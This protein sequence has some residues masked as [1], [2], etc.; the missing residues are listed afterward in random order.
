M[1]AKAVI[2]SLVVVFILAQNSG[3][4]DSVDIAQGDTAD[5]QSTSPPSANN[6]ATATSTSGGIAPQIARLSILQPRQ[7]ENWR[8]LLTPYLG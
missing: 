6:F 7:P 1:L 2:I 4:D 3:F 5:L 8:F